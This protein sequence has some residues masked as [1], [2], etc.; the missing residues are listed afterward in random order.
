MEKMN[1]QLH[2]DC[3]NLQIQPYGASICSQHESSS[4]RSGRTF[5][6]F[7]RQQHFAHGPG[8]VSRTESH[9]PEDIFVK[10]VLHQEPNV[11]GLISSAGLRKSET[12][13]GDCFR[14]RKPGSARQRRWPQQRTNPFVSSTRWSQP[15]ERPFLSRTIATSDLP[16]HAI[17][18][19]CSQAVKYVVTGDVS[20]GGGPRRWV[21]KYW[22]LTGRHTHL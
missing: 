10:N 11:S 7:Q 4:L 14:R 21:L 9:W 15:R 12:L 5:R 20:Q 18:C 17:Q 22:M 13:L 6:A 2:E 16:C 19:I 3:T 1:P 8:Y